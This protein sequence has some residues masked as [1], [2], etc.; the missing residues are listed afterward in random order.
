MRVLTDITIFTGFSTLN[1]IDVARPKAFESKRKGEMRSA[2]LFV[3]DAN[4]V[5]YHI[6]GLQ[7]PA[8]Q[9]TVHISTI[10]TTS[11]VK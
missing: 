11:E 3:D 9:Q 5:L 1:D 4:Y 6:N 7:Q 10:S 2:R 8:T